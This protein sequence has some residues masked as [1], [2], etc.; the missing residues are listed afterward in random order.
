MPS[1]YNKEMG[2]SESLDSRDRSPLDLSLPLASLQKKKKERGMRQGLGWFG[3]NSNSNLN[4]NGN[5]LKTYKKSFQSFQT[6]TIGHSQ[7][8]VKF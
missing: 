1:K 8:L 6:Q 4:S 2:F 3:Q 7:V 5:D